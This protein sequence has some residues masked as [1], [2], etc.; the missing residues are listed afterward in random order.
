MDTAAA[1]ASIGNRGKLLKT[2]QKK[3]FENFCQLL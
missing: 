2:I 1:R 3:F